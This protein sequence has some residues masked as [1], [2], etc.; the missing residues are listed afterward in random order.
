MPQL[1]NESE[2]EYLD[3]LCT[4]F[5]DDTEN[6]EL[7]KGVRCLGRKKRQQ[8]EQRK[9]EEAERIVKEKAKTE[10]DRKATEA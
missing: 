5:A 7:D 10:A 1:A 6:L 8:E 2:A 9:R 3:W 4:M